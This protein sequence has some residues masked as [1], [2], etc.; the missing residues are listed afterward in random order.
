MTCKGINTSR[1]NVTVNY[2]RAAQAGIET[3]AGQLVK[4]KSGDDE[5]SDQIKGWSENTGLA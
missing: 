3:G 1:L 5:V 2:Q 4:F